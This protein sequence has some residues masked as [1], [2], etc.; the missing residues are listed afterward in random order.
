MIKEVWKSVPSYEDKYEISNSGYVRNYK[1]KKLLAF[2]KSNRGYLRV[3]L[4]NGGISKKMSVHRI[5]AEVFLDN[6]NQYPQVN[7]KDGNKENNLVDNLEW[8]TCKE[9]IM[10]A[11][12]NGLVIWTPERRKKMSEIAGKRDMRKMHE[13]ARIANIGRHHGQKTKE[14]MSKSRKGKN[15]WCAISIYCPETGELFET[16]AEAAQKY[17]VCHESMRVAVKKGTTCCGLHWKGA[18][19]E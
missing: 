6:P 3:C 10:H 14:K 17:N 18:D 5:V 11:I 19:D 7:H 12:R 2:T 13:A 8:C 16:I 4:C 1:T 9:N 15:T